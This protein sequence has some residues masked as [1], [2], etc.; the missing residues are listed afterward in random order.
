[1]DRYASVMIGRTSPLELSVENRI[2]GSMVA[3]AV[4]DALGWPQEMRPTNSN[5]RT[6]RSVPTGTG[7]REWQRR[8]GGRF[9]NRVE[10]VQA[11]EY[12]DDTQLTLCTARSLIRSSLW[13]IDFTHS[14][15]P[16]WTVYQRGAGRSTLRAANAWL[17]GT[18]P[19]SLASPKDKE[20]YWQ[21]GGNG[22]AMRIH[23]HSLAWMESNE[24]MPLGIELATNA[25]TTHGH[26]RAIIGAIVHGFVVWRA[27]QKQGTL[28][29]GEPVTWALEGLELLT[30]MPSVESTWPDWQ[31][32]LK[33][34]RPGYESLWASVREEMLV[35]LKLCQDGVRQGALAVD[36]DVLRRLGCFDRGTGGAGTVSAAAAV[37]L[38]SRFAPEPL[39]GLREA[40][41]AIGADTDTIASM[42]GS[43]LGAIHG[44]DHLD[45]FVDGLQDLDYLTDIAR[46]LADPERQ[47]KA[48]HEPR[49]SVTKSALVKTRDSL[50]SRLE[51]QPV[52]LP[53]RRGGMVI[54]IL[55][56]TGQ[57]GTTSSTSW[58]IKT[59][60]G[61]TIYITSVQ[62]DAKE[63][64]KP[65]NAAADIGHRGTARVGVKLAVVEPARMA[66]FFHDVFGLATKEASTHVNIG[67]VLAL[68][69]KEF[70][71]QPSLVPDAQEPLI[72]IETDAIERIFNLV[73]SSDG[74]IIQGMDR[75]EN[76]RFFICEDPGGNRVEVI[77]K[78][79]T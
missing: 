4:G 54:E 56:T 26:P 78:R 61:Q 73:L 38:A 13:W 50:K 75:R 12:S 17:S 23:P 32:V 58:R 62:R 60:D 48:S 24:F 28:A 34:T 29:Y 31:F 39:H 71:G 57:P 6:S 3:G 9:Y 55:R 10:R 42:T 36:S 76:R 53:D 14:E 67:G 35:L 52:A 64:G 19:W 18:A 8:T 45:G 77:E 40:A 21:A 33:S 43:I 66:K 47:D 20:E 59:D 63:S 51:E 74:R 70:D 79:S 49:P 7:F 46:R 27:V 25:L 44:R 69:A 15:L 1:M 41:F 22:A 72:F 30:E 16:A 68:V 5:T 11:G 37:F 65:D 2:V